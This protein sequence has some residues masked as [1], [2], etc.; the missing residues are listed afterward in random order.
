MK[1]KVFASAIALLIVTN[2][3][4]VAFAQT[5]TQKTPPT[6]VQETEKVNNIRQLLDL[7]GAK[8]ISQQ[9]M[10]QTLD[11]LKSQYPQVPQKVWDTFLAEVKADEMI[12][13]IVPIYNKY[14]TGEEIKQII[15]FYQTPLGKKTISVLPQ[16]SRDSAIIGQKYGI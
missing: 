16:I 12:N 10:L 4:Q 8:N 9:I 13:E 5:P 7:T 15:A 2:I 14:F 3:N 6:S 1:M 11:V